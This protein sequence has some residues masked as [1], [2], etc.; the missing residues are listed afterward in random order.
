VRSN[1]VDGSLAVH[2]SNAQLIRIR[3]GRRYTDGENSKTKKTRYSRGRLDLH[4]VGIQSLEKTFR[5]N[6]NFHDTFF[7]CRYLLS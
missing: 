5:R 3:G 2:D 1:V 6:S 7:G 4:T